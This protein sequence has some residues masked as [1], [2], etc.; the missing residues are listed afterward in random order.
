MRGA[1]LVATLAIAIALPAGAG[2]ASDAVMNVGFGPAGFA[3]QTQT[4]DGVVQSR[5]A[6]P[7]DAIQ[8]APLPDGG[9]VFSNRNARTAGIWLMHPDG[10]LVHLTDDAWDGNPNAVRDG[11]RVVF[12][13]YD[14]ATETNDIYAV[15]GDGTGLTA[16]THGEGKANYYQPEFSPDGSTIAFG[17]VSKQ[18]NF[19]TQFCGPQ[20]DGGYWYHGVML[21]NADGTQQ[22]MIFRSQS[23]EPT[24]SNDGKWLAVIAMIEVHVVGG[25]TGYPEL[26][27]VKSDGSDL[28]ADER[29]ERFVP[30]SDDPSSLGL[31]DLS[32]SPDGARVLFGAVVIP[33]SADVLFVVDRDGDHLTRLALD[34]NLDA[35]FVPPASGEGPPP[36]VDMTHIVVPMVAA[37]TPRAARAR[38]E[39]RHLRVIGV[40]K[41]YSK[42]PRG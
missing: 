14:P 31:Y 33:E 3:I 38:I 41:R 39:A 4:L 27:V 9:A 6:L 13:R 29:A 1:S 42:L 26:Y 21:M 40:E 35:R 36:T 24:W 22:R 12:D 17:C 37:L 8:V 20:T 15:N 10:S 19:A 18:I 11:S 25:I 32:F 2:A 16:L 30:T 34:G 5:L 7:I 23:W 28:F